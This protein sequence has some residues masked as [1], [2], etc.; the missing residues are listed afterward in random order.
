MSGGLQL[1]LWRVVAI[2]QGGIIYLR[3]FNHKRESSYAENIKQTALQPGAT[4]ESGS[5]L[6]GL[7]LGS[8]GY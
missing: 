5:L 1:I 7:L 3:H 6:P 4:R 8:I 2:E